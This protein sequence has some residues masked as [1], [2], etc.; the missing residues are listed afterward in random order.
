MAGKV[1]SDIYNESARD[2]GDTTTTHIT[3]VKKKVNDALRAICAMMRFSWLQREADVTLVASQQYVNMSDIATDWDEDMPS[4]IFYR[5][6]ANRRQVLDVLDDKEWDDEADIDEGDPYAYHITIKSG[7]WRVLFTLVPDSNFV[8]DYSP[9]KMEYQKKPDE[10]DDDT[11][12]PELPTGHHQLLVYY[13]NMLVSA[14]MD[15]D[16]G[17]KRW[18]ALVDRGLGA[19][20]R[21]QVHRLGRPK[22]VTPRATMTTAGQ[23]YK[24]RDYNRNVI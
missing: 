9:L 14:E 2:T 3:Y 22:R 7:V 6:S 15:D 20:K 1:F 23:R 21:R 11:D 8:S 16:A 17:M 4:I 24:A 18:A 19:L 10:L 13:T 5:D 12:V